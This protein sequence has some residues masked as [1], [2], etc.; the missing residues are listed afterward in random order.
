M[1][2]RARSCT[3]VAPATLPVVLRA[4]I[5]VRGRSC[6]A[7]L[8][9]CAPIR[10]RRYQSSV[11]R[12][13]ARR[14]GGKEA[15]GCRTPPGTPDRR[16]APG[17]AQPADC[18]RWPDWSPWPWRPRLRHRPH[19]R[20]WR[21]PAAPAGIAAPRPRTPSRCCATGPAM[22]RPSTSGGTWASSWHRASSPRGCPTPSS[23][24][25]PRPSSSTPGT[26]PSRAI[27]GADIA[28]RAASAMTSVTTPWTSST[29]P[30]RPTH[31]PTSSV[32]S[33]RHGG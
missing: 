31:G 24:S 23:R 33:L 16:H 11:R 10:C 21:G 8:R 17:R 22:S 20:C 18:C 1:G 15:D 2:W 14:S 32:P 7:Q 4:R 30:R 3:R 9:G 19:R 28:P 25:A 13:P 6:H 26:T 5:R 12:A 27:T 29:A